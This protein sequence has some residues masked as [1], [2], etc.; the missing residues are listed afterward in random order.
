M[1]NIVNRLIKLTSD[2]AMRI[3]VI[4]LFFLI[5]PFLSPNF[6]RMNNFMNILQNI[7]L[8]GI[9][10][11]GMT[12]VIIMGG[13]DISVGGVLALSV[14]VSAAIMQAGHSVLLAAGVAIMIGIICGFINGFT[15]GVLKIP[16]MIATLAMMY[17]TRGLQTMISRGT[18][19][20]GFPDIFKALGQGDVLGIPTP[21]IIVIGLYLLMNWFLKKTITGR[22]IFTV[23]GNPEAAEI[24]GIKN[25]RI[26]FLSYILCSVFAVI[27]GLVFISRMDSAPSLIGNQLEMS[28]IMAVVIGGTAITYGGKGTMIGTFL[29]VII[30]G[31]ITNALDLAG[32]SVYYQQFIQGVLILSVVGLEA[33]KELRKARKV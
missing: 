24:A 2:H 17:I 27:A 14:W 12:I 15:I 23:G 29:G 30:V 31:L 21:A 26:V 7:S 8:Q 19:I 3:M 11:I 25:Q 10:A 22:N 4:L 16:P 20:N 32:V 33:I 1:K 18:T 9:T 28:A 13:I 5:M 6:L